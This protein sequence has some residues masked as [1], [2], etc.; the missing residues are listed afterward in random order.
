[1]S[2][3]LKIGINHMAKRIIYKGKN[4]TLDIT[5]NSFDRTCASTINTMV[6]VAV[7]VLVTIFPLYYHNDYYDILSAKFHFY[8]RCVLILLAAIL[9]AA[10]IMICIDI[11]K[12]D[13]EH[14]LS[15]LSRFLPQ[16]WKKHFKI[17]DGAVLL[18]WILAAVSTLLS[19]Y[20]H[21][22]FWGNEGRYSGLY[23][24]TMYVVLYFLISHFWKIKGVY[25]ELFLISGTLMGILGIGDFFQL[26][27]LNFRTEDNWDALAVFTSTIGNINTYTAYIGMVMGF[28]VTLFAVEKKPL[29]L[30]WYY[31][32]MFISFF[33]MITGRSDNSYLS[34]GILFVLLPF[35]LFKNKKGIQ[36][37]MIILATFF[38]AVYLVNV[39]NH[40]FADRALQLGGLFHMMADFPGLPFIAF[41]LWAIGIGLQFNRQDSNKKLTLP[42]R[43]WGGVMI[44][45]FLVIVLILMDANLRGH[46]KQYGALESFVVFN[47][48]WG[49][50]RG[51]VWNKAIWLYNRLPFFQKLIGSGPDT[52]AC[53]ANKKLVYIMIKD[54]GVFF[55]TV[56]NAYLQYLVTN[57]ILGLTFYLIFLGNSFFHLFRN[58]KR[59]PYIFAALMASICYALQ[60]SVNLELPIVTPTFWLLL[61]IGMAGCR[62]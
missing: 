62:E 6:G 39:L 50:G 11:K 29:K 34:I 13:G 8:S 61:S 51:Y 1:M 38:T 58:S 48:N 56:H 23:L 43:I 35:I 42:T 12:Y 17:A 30:V 36:R 3:A 16:N 26:D 27:L 37:Y 46:G 5:E 49:S 18:F 20:T 15:F 14:T 31:V 41:L 2:I 47:D 28:A 54:T 9:V 55:D 45:G 53:L 25:L 52:F 24:L 19:D 10:L 7:L 59:N 21:E 60:A 44:A 32:C 33:A 22:A 57:G 40:I 4:N